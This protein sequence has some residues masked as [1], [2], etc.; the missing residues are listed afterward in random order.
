MSAIDLREHYLNYIAT[1]N[2]RRFED[3][4]A[5]AADELVYNGAPMTGRQYHELLEDDVRRIPDL[6]FDV[7]HLVVDNGYVACRLR[8]HPAR[9][10]PG[11]AAHRVTRG[12]RRARLLPGSRRPHHPGVV[13][14]RRR[15]TAK[16]ATP[17]GGLT[18]VH[19][20][21]T[22]VGE[23]HAQGCSSVSFR[24]DTLGWDVAEDSGT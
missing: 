17:Q 7:Q 23:D 13:P 12:V 8:L 3:L 5:F 1:L 22:E 11:T 24:S 15:G 21:A 6:F 14:S 16:A 10:V 4:P 2:E 18:K 19:P 9:A 20:A